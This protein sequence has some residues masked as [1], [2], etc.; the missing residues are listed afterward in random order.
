MRI[1]AT[2]STPAILTIEVR[3]SQKR[4]AAPLVVR[5][6]DVY[7]VSQE[8]FDNS[9]AIKDALA[10]G[11]IA[12]D[13]EDDDYL[14]KIEMEQG[15][16]SIYHILTV[17]KNPTTV[18][19][20]S[21]AAACATITDSSTTNRYVVQVGPGTYSEPLIIVPTFVYVVGPSIDSV[22]VAPN[23]DHSVFR[24]IDRAGIKHLTIRD[25]PSGRYGVECSDIGNF[26]LMHKVSILSCATGILHSSTSVDSYLFLEY[27]DFTDCGI[28][29]NAIANSSKICSLNCENLYF[30]FT[31]SN[32]TNAFIINGAT[33]SCNVQGATCVG[34]GGT[35]NGFLAT[36]GAELT[37]SSIKIANFGRA[38]YA[39][40]TGNQ[41][42]VMQAMD[43]SECSKNFE[44][45]SAT[46][47]GYF[48]GYSE[49]TKTTINSSSEFFIANSDGHTVTVGMKGAQYESI[50]A[51][52]E[53]I[54]DSG[55]SNRYNIAVGP[56]TYQEDTITCRDYVTISGDETRCTIVELKAGAS[57]NDLFVIP[58]TVNT[59][60]RKLLI[61]NATSGAAIRY[62]GGAVS[63][64]QV[65]FGSNLVCVDAS[66]VSGT[67][68]SLDILDCST[69]RTCECGLILKASTDG[70][71]SL[72]CVVTNFI[73]DD[74]P[75]GMTD[76]AEVGIV[77]GTD[78]GTN[79]MVMFI[80]CSLI[81]DGTGTAIEVADGADLHILGSMIKGF[82]IGVHSPSQG[83]GPE[84]DATGDLIYDNT[85]YDWLVAHPLAAG[86]IS[87]ISD[88]TKISVV[89][90]ADI[91]V[92][93][94]GSED[95]SLMLVGDFYQ[96][97]TFAGM[98][99]L[100][101]QITQGATAGL[102]TGGGLSRVSGL[103]LQVAAGTGYAYSTNPEVS[104]VK[105]VSWGAA[106]KTIPANSAYF[107]Y[108]DS[109][110][111][112]V[113]YSEAIPSFY[114]SITLGRV[115]TTATSL[116][117]VAPISRRMTAISSRYDNL[118]RHYIGPIYNS[119][120]T[121]TASNLKLNVSEGSYGYSSWEF[122]PT[123][124]SPI[125][126]STWYRDVANPGQ[127]IT[128][129]SL[130]DVPTDY[131]DKEGVGL[132]ELT[133]ATHYAKH[134]LYIFGGA[135]GE[136]EQYF[137]QYGQEEFDSKAAA[138]A[139]ALPNIPDFFRLSVASIAAIVVH[140]TATVIDTVLDERPTLI[141]K[142]GVGTSATSDHTS[143]SNLNSGDAGH[144]QFLLLNGTTPMTDDL[145]LDNHNLITGTGLVDGVDV[146][147]HMARHLPNGLDALTTAAP[148]AN[149]STTST[150]YEGTQAKFA[151]SDH[152]HA[153]TTASANTASTIVARD[154]SGNFSAGMVTANL[155]G[156]VTGNTSGSA[157]TFTTALSGD[158]TGGNNG[159]GTA[160]AFVGGS[161]A[162]S[163]ASATVAANAATD[164][165]TV[166]TIVKRDG[167]GNFSAGTIT[168]T[169]SGNATGTA[170]NIT[171]VA[172]IAN[173][174]TNSSSALSNNR[175]MVSS[176]SKIVEAS[177]ITASAA[178]VSDSNGLPTASSTTTTELSYVH[179]VTGGIQ[180][181]I[182]AK[183]TSSALSSHT[184]NTSNPHSTTL[185]QA[186]TAG[187]SLSGNI[188]AN[189]N[190][191]INLPDPE[192]AGDAC[193]KHYA[194]ATAS[195]LSVKDPCRMATTAAL[196]V[197][198][199][200]ITKAMTNAG[201]NAVLVLDTVTAI[202]T[203]RVLVKDQSDQKQNGIYTVSDIGAADPGGHAWV[204]TRASDF[205]ASAE[206]TN[207]SF[208]LV[209]AG[210]ANIGAGYV[211]TTTP[212]ITLDSSNLTWSKFSQSSTISPGAGLALNGTAFDV[213]VDNATL[214]INL[215]NNLEVKASGI[216][217]TQLN[218]ANISLSGFGVPTGDISL[219]SH[220]ITT[221]AAPGSNA[222]AARKID[223]DT[224]QT[225]LT[226]H[227]GTGGASHAQVTSGADGFMIAAD[228]TKLD[229]ATN[230]NTASAIVKRDGSGNFTAGT[231]TANLT[232][233]V[234][235]NASGSAATF[236]TAL[237][238]DV[239]GGANGGVNA[240]A[241]VG[242]ST[243]ANVHSAELAANAATNSNTVSTI[244]KRDGSG[245]FSAGTITAS[246]TGNVTGTLTGN[247]TGSAATFTTALNG[248]VTGGASGGANTVAY[249]GTSTA[250]NVHSAELAAN[251]A[252][253]AN[254]VS[255]IVKRDSSGNFSAGM[256]TANLTGT[257]TG[258][259]SNGV[260]SASGTAPLTLT[261]AANALTGSIAAATPSVAG[262]MS[263]ADKA[264]LDGMSG[265]SA[266]SNRTTTTQN[267]TLATGVNV[268]NMSLPIAANEVWTYEF[269]V[270][271]TGGAAGTKFALTVPAGCAIT[272]AL[273]GT[274]NNTGN[275][276][277]QGENLTV[278]GTLS[279]ISFM[280]G[281][282][283]H[284][285]VTGIAVNGVTAGTIQLQF[286]AATAGQTS[287]IQARSFVT[288][289]TIA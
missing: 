62:H 75:S 170:A 54:S 177:A 173:G 152:T 33:A 71:H 106:Q 222:D 207:G 232:G 270:F 140:K 169:L 150:N 139:G 40:S 240:V 44:I 35:G 184:G 38:V 206:I 12:V 32:P 4:A 133:D 42:V 77:S 245:N 174:G 120:S 277:F 218:K 201:A 154:A 126:F 224:V 160:V 27:V 144:H 212:P 159:G 283:G 118:F 68:N 251:A 14:P 119:G 156:N 230:L 250:A 167:S 84:I 176:G 73:T 275:L 113:K 247:A 87:S 272:A 134:L 246:L 7:S 241:Y 99:D 286:A 254:T 280:P 17:C 175:V 104:T 67:E 29:V 220:K 265:G 142:S 262:Y 109:A 168:A 183:A 180:G 231:I 102:T 94:Q 163:V 211:L 238:G 57:T 179:G 59:T 50:K 132:T 253:N 209:T 182:D 53:S 259:A 185:E 137:L 249:V 86:T 36:N 103:V 276:R 190:T 127:W 197:T 256:I 171:G 117:L 148:T 74:T 83:N 11:Y 213:Q 289:R 16:G 158:V 1:S 98:T 111:S 19:F 288:G 116:I 178:L 3:D 233:S 121:V 81:G 181:Q 92:L 210:S 128:T 205:D 191:I 219:N 204:M 278:S 25:A 255:T 123:G 242:T 96:G 52:M 266:G 55:Y 258:N 26:S 273:Y 18:Q 244:V 115:L 43:F 15:F 56:G 153:I 97:S 79:T 269:I 21:I 267:T 284:V 143:L 89:S 30:E 217:D 129:E 203:N 93:G 85:T 285:S 108:V 100:T 24:L 65:R 107:I 135:G 263:A 105:Y 189:S 46:A 194:D 95:G 198:Y 226:N 124:A 49:S 225:N 61:R 69:A 229:A 91:S 252:T 82:N 274:S 70:T 138:E 110:D 146:S 51:A 243:A 101:S 72:N 271:C 236:T 164:A 287:T 64:N 114:S 165:N 60:I 193:N 10:R 45:A 34:I 157:A 208:T 22:V 131:Y 161:A 66:G 78:R 186:R 28:V 136:P 37:M 76:F 279:T 187:S 237:T 48:V 20:S 2:G 166:S 23:G 257:V 223:V 9:P 264:K 31:S 122:Y 145:D 141:T 200:S 196:N 172:A 216:G 162:A 239:T 130:T 199:S 195:G 149:L 125:T 228:K 188:D 8:L 234:T 268:T 215:S 147:G 6:G 248:D 41:H 5:R 58:S 281:F 151:R 47:T 214:D 39:D 90:G 282:T 13:Y 227:I 63:L 260:N 202:A 235:G 112:T 88:R 261:L 155:T 80:G 192:N 221:L